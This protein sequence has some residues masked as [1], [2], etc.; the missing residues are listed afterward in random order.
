MNRN[1]LSL[2]T[3]ATLFYGLLFAVSP[4]LPAAPKTGKYSGKTGTRKN[5]GRISFKVIQR[6]KKVTKLTASAFVLC[7]NTN[8]FVV[9]AASDKNKKF[10][11]KGRRRFKA[12]GQD[13]NGVRYEVDGKLRGSKKFKGDVEVSQFRSY[14][15]PFFPFISSQVCAGSRPYTAKR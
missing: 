9:V 12:A 2:L 5:S 15:I 3:A 7:P 10:R 13:K 11:I 4:D 1:K 14:S 6:G 8:E